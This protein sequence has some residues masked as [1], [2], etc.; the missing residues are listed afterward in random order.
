[1]NVLVAGPFRS[2]KRTLIN[3]AMETDKLAPIEQDSFQIFK[4]N[5]LTLIRSISGYV[6]T[7]LND[8]RKLSRSNNCR[9]CWYVIP[10]NANMQSMKIMISEIKELMPVIFVVTKL[11]GSE[12]K[13]KDII[14]KTFG[15]QL[16]VEFF[17]YSP[18]NIQNNKRNINDLIKQT[19]VL[20]NINI[21]PKNHET[22]EDD[23]EHK[24]IYRKSTLDPS[25]KYVIQNNI[26]N[27][28]LNILILGPR[29]VNKSIIIESLIPKGKMKTT[30]NNFKIFESLSAPK[31]FMNTRRHSL[32]IATL[33]HS[34][35]KIIWIYFIFA[36]VLSTKILIR[37]MSPFLVH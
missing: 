23:A 4:N 7:F 12:N 10:A 6:P 33:L 15:S 2:G 29:E 1:M 32:Q 5:R 36:G 28:D 21:S 35:S 31:S 27:E 13:L 22:Q 17:D 3:C 34:K 18:N 19:E 37:Y 24:D 16:K 26:F 11:D 30:N 9:I 20:L 8:Y 14:M 25:N